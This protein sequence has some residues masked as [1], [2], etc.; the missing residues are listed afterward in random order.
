MP[1]IILSIS[2]SDKKS[3]PFLSFFVKRDM[4]KPDKF[5]KLVS[6]LYMRTAAFIS[7]A[8]LLIVSPF[9]QTCQSADDCSGQAMSCCCGDSDETA[10]SECDAVFK[11][12]CGCYLSEGIP[13]E[14]ILVYAQTESNKSAKDLTSDYNYTRIEN[15]APIPLYEPS[16][17]RFI[18]FRGL[19]PPLFILHSCLII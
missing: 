9:V 19:S 11:S 5:M 2:N 7:L 18:S 14:E 1:P 16:A 4:K 10:P 13:T 8:I 15:I 6:N 12:E 17:G 3:E